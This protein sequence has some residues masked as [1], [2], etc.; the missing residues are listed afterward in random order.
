MKNHI[1]NY[2]KILRP[3][4]VPFGTAQAHGDP[5][6][7]SINVSRCVWDKDDRQAMVLIFVGCWF[8]GKLEGRGVPVTVFWHKG[9]DNAP[10]VDL[11]LRFKNLYNKRGDILLGS[12]VKEIKNTVL[13]CLGGKCTFTDIYRKAFVPEEG[14]REEAFCLELFLIDTNV[15]EFDDTVL[16]VSQ[17][18]D[19]IIDSPIHITSHV[20]TFFA[21]RGPAC[22]GYLRPESFYE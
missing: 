14:S 22:V 21:D 4:A 7:H 20:R 10:S 2:I 19:G 1:K 11:G 13:G 9:K 3:V 18:Q 5:T 8:E 12:E 15:G 16:L 17:K 6:E